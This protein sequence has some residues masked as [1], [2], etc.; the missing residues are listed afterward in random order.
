M[1]LYGTCEYY[2]N[3]LGTEYEVCSQKPIKVHFH[4]F[5]IFAI[6]AAEKQKK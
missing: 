3:V 2:L 6:K 4:K 5:E 1:K